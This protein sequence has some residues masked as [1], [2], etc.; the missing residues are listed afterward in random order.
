MSPT[1]SPELRIGGIEPFSTVDWPGELV[2][3]VFCQGCSWDCPYCHNPTLKEM[4]VPAE[5]SVAWSDVLRLL[6]DRRGLVDGVVFSG[7]EPT[8]QQGLVRAAQQVSGSGFAVGLHTN[9]ARPERLAAVLPYLS[10]VGF[11][12]KA[13]FPRYER[14]TGFPGA[15]SAAAASLD[16]LVD[17]G[18]ALEVRTTVHSALLQPEDLVEM[19][20]SLADAGVRRW[21]LQTCRGREALRRLGPDGGI[22]RYRDAVDGLIDEIVVR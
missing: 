12:L 17:S 6:E 8:L 11:D 18:V 20:R 16:L 5:R 21:V 4:T 1:T 7:G 2:V 13:P 22:S 3:T 14:V 10:W 19:A 15:G 9:G